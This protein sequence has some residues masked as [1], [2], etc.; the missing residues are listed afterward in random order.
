LRGKEISRL[1]DAPFDSGDHIVKLNTAFLAKGVYII[2]LHADQ[3]I[4]NQKLFVQ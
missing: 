4:F 1:V 3:A 2:T